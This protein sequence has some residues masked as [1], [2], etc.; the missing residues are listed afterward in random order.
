MNVRAI[1]PVLMTDRVEESRRFYAE[2][3]DLDLAFD[4]DWFV[5]LISAGS[6]QAQMGMVASDHESIPAA[7]RAAGAGFLVTVEVEDVDSVYER[8]V[9]RGTPIKLSLRDE[10]WGQRHFIARD[11]NGIAVDVVKVI[12]VTSSEAAAHYTSPPA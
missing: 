7:F 10:E 5:Q 1:Y 11:P 4:S 12:P 9:S 3:L 6:D 8:A 2:L